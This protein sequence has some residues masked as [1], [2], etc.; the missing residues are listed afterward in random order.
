[1]GG[2]GLAHIYLQ[3]QNTQKGQKR[4]LKAHLHLATNLFILLFMNLATYTMNP[5]SF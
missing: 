5:Y 2:Q 4:V 1:M 3:E